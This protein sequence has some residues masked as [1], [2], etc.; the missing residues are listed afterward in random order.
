MAV[1]KD[2]FPRLPYTKFWPDKDQIERLLARAQG[3]SSPVPALRDLFSLISTYQTLH[4]RNN[5]WQSRQWG[6]TD[7]AEENSEH[8]NY[9]RNSDFLQ[10]VNGAYKWAAN[11]ALTRSITTTGLPYGVAR[12]GSIQDTSGAK[13]WVQQS[14][15][16][17]GNVWYGFGG[18]CAVPTGTTAGFDVVENSGSSS[19][20]TH[21]LYQ[22][23]TVW[24]RLQGAFRTYKGT[25]KLTFRC[26]VASLTTGVFAQL[27]LEKGRRLH[28]WRKH[29]LDRGNYVTSLKTANSASFWGNIT[30]SASGGAAIRQKATKTFV[31]GAPTVSGA[32][33]KPVSTSGAAGILVTYSR[34]DHVHRGVKAIKTA[35]ASADGTVAISASGIG[36]AVRM[37]GAKVIVGPPKPSTATPKQ[38][39]ASGAVGTGTKWSRE[40]H[41]HRGVTA[42]KYG[43]TSNDGVVSFSG[44]GTGGALAWS[45]TKLKL[46][47]PKPAT[48][49]PSAVS[50]S[51]TVG[52]GTLWARTDH[53]HRGVKAIKYGATSNSATVSFSGSGTAASMGLAWA[54]KKLKIGFPKAATATPAA[55]STSGTVGT[56]TLWAR[57]DHRHRGVK[58]VGTAG[59][60]SFAGS[61]R[62]S[63]STNAA[64]RQVAGPPRKFVIGA[65][66]GG[67]NITGLTAADLALADELP[68]YNIAAAANRKITGTKIGGFLAIGVSELRLTLTSATPVTTADVTAA[69][70]IY[71]TPYIGNRIRL[72]DGT[73]WNE[74]QTAEVSLA[75]TATSGKPYD[76]FAYDNA[77]TVTLETLV[78]TDD[79]TR[80]T[81]LTTQNGVYVKSGDATRLYLGSFY[82]S[83]LNV[84]ED[85]VK[86][87]YL[88]NM[89]HRV[90]RPMSVTDAT[91]SWTY[92]TA[93]WRQA[94]ASAANQLSMMRGLNIDAVTAHVYILVHNSSAGTYMSPGVGI[95]STS[96]NS[97]QIHGGAAYVGSA[98]PHSAF[99]NGL[100]G[101]GRHYLVWVEIS[102]AAG[103]TTWY[104]DNG[105]LILQ[106]G[107]IAE[108]LA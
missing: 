17:N 42:V 1:N 61:I 69:G 75:L 26:V 48:A 77:G 10:G 67:L 83:G 70:T 84:T 66:G 60:A 79:T 64:I 52:T 7:V 55:P 106:A 98:H 87:R 30:L 15:S 65:T 72:W 51:G 58:S 29:L 33:P 80:A 34:A 31:F 97:A 89:Y 104:G 108:V 100:P 32:K 38:V 103:T 63:A 99:Y 105:G 85:S 56:G 21:A 102:T 94:N 12:G 20:R 35:V 59:S 47:W 81:A 86:L 71:L 68:E 50:T 8:W 107:M 91:D 88:W 11:A 22:G 23:T 6:L 54:G 82:A 62:L 74:R 36:S 43:G 5:D 37:T 96:T 9:I 16:A 13:N 4:Q 45:G 41:V 78:W 3:G 27:M 39:S 28:S 90:P 57:T 14:A 19:G 92:T 49:T 2:G 93:T 25:T 73:R 18:W 40:D 101:V 44:S 46:G 53:R 76:V 24:K 95:D